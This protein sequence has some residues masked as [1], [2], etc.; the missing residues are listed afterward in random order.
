MRVY[1]YSYT[2]TRRRIDK[3]SASVFNCIRNN[4][5][6]FKET[7][8]IRQYDVWEKP[9]CRKKYN[10]KRC[11]E[12]QKFCFCVFSSIQIHVYVILRLCFFHTSQ[13]LGSDSP[14]AFRQMFSFCVRPLCIKSESCVNYLGRKPLL[15]GQIT[16]YY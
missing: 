10:R 5:R 3:E 2:H 11:A 14:T 13:S 1:T 8:Y 9:V 7:L 6:S 4:L 15:E 12:K 16:S